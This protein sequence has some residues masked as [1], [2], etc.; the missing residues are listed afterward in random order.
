MTVNLGTMGGPSSLFV[1]YASALL[2]LVCAADSL[3]TL[4]RK[5]AADERRLRTMETAWL[6]CHIELRLLER[7]LRQHGLEVQTQELAKEELRRQLSLPSP[8]AA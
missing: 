8:N 7:W 2:G 1:A 3:A 5:R 4:S 6:E